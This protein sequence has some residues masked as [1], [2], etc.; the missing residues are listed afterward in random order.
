LWR[1]ASTGAALIWR[2]DGFTRLAAGGIG[3]VPLVWEVQ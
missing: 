1:N 2:M 3:G